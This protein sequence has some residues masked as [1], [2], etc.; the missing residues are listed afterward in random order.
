MMLLEAIDSLSWTRTNRPRIQKMFDLIRDLFSKDKPL[1]QRLALGTILAAIAL[2]AVWKSIP[3]GQRSKIIERAVAPPKPSPIS[4]AADSAAAIEGRLPV[5]RDSIGLVYYAKPGE[6][7][8]S[9]MLMELLQRRGFAV[10][11]HAPVRAE[12]SDAVWCG[13]KV[14]DGTCVIAALRMI[15]SGLRVRQVFRF[16]AGHKV[17][18]VEIGHNANIARIDPLTPV[19]VTALLKSGIAVDRTPP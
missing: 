18:R 3:E 12:Q 2:F 10:S 14:S 4:V 6:A 5:Q 17:D 1:A 9:P 16:P 7:Q 11:V 15:Q 13:S 19:Q 8:V